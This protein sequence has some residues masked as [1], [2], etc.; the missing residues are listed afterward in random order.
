MGQFWWACRVRLSQVSKQ[1]LCRGQN[2][3]SEN[4]EFHH[5]MS[6]VVSADRQAK[7]S[8]PCKPTFGTVTCGQS[9]E[10]ETVNVRVLS[11]A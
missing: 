1:K 4:R 3:D 9:P 2:P 11:E 5:F 10:A 8:N 6:K 7:C